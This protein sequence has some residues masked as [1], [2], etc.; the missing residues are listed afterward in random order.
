MS[1][2]ERDVQRGAVEKLYPAPLAGV[3][4]LADRVMHPDGE[5]ETVDDAELKARE[6]RQDA[7]TGGEETAELAMTDALLAEQQG[8]GLLREVRDSE[9]VIASVPGSWR[10]A[11]SA[12][13]DLGGLATG[14]VVTF[15]GS[16][17]RADGAVEHVRSEVTVTS[18]GDYRTEE[19]ER[20]VLVNF[21]ATAPGMLA[22]AAADNRAL[23]ASTG[24]PQRSRT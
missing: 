15:E 12:G 17:H 5:E 11:D 13:A 2:D 24:V 14:A 6:D 23:P 21:R 16:L 4:P 19:G 7:D 1:V 10:P 8:S 9:G 3:E 22:H 20:L 18:V